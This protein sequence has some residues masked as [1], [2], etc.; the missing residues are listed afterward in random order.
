LT[1]KTNYADHTVTINFPKSSSIEEVT[2]E[3]L[4]FMYRD[5]ILTDR[6]TIYKSRRITYDELV[7]ILNYYNLPDLTC[8]EVIDKPFISYTF[9][10]QSPETRESGVVQNIV[11]DHLYLSAY[12][13]FE[14]QI[15]YFGMDI[16][17]NCIVTAQT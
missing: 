14:T 10:L 13:C 1:C 7:T 3:N 2:K 6:F 8:F 11:D 12:D 16:Y 5:N 17:T 9:L 15:A 4:E